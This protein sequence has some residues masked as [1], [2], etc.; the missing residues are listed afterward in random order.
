MRWIA[1]WF[2]LAGIVAFIIGLVQLQGPHDAWIVPTICLIAAVAMLTGVGL[3]RGWQAARIVGLV[4]SVGGVLTGL[5][6]LVAF[7]PILDVLEGGGLTLSPV[8]VWTLLFIACGWVLAPS[9]RG[10]Q[11]G[12]R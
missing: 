8:I 11:A 4:L 9:V 2:I 7:V 10:V 5:A 6:V 1:V 3:L 12:T